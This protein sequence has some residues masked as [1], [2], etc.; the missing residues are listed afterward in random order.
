[1]YTMRMVSW[2]FLRDAAN[3]LSI[4][5]AVRRSSFV[6]GQDASISLIRTGHYAV[7][8]VELSTGGYIARVGILQSDSFDPQNNGLYGVAAY[9]RHDQ[10]Y[11]YEI[12]EY[13]H[14]SGAQIVRPLAYERTNAGYDILWLPYIAAAKRLASTDEWISLISSIQDVSRHDAMPVFGN[15]QKTKTRLETLKGGERLLGEYEDLMKRLFDVTTRW[16]VVH[17]DLHVDNVLVTDAGILAYDLDTIGWSPAVWELTHLGV[18]YGQRGNTGYDIDVIRS[19][20]GFTER[21][22]KTAYQLRLLASR[23][24]RMAV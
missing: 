5:E 12:G 21:E 9:V 6:N 16:S 1:M 4:E 24:A 23:I 22:Y 11:E 3:T 15:Y 8:R 13:C 14:D 2:E 7:F 19:A 20:L 18:R 10:L 17:G